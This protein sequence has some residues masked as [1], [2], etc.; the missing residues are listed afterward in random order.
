MMTRKSGLAAISAAVLL[1]ACGQGGGAKTTGMI[2]S[3][4]VLDTAD[5]PA[6]IG[7][8]FDAPESLRDQDAG[9]DMGKMSSCGLTSTAPD[10]EPSDLAGMAAQMQNTWFVTLMAWTWPGEDSAR[11]YMDSMRQSDMLGSAPENVA[12]LGD[13]AVWNGSM[14][15]RRGNVTLSMDVRGPAAESGERSEKALEAEL[16]KRVLKALK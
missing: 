12:D 4:A 8:A 3:C 15:V 10:N 9:E 11:G 6:L 16:L 2:N 13:D 1:A 5:A 14:H 7:V